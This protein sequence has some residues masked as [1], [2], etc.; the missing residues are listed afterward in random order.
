MRRGDLTDREKAI[1]EFIVE[2]KR[3]GITPTV[4]EIGREVGLSS[5]ATVFF[6]LRKL[7]EKGY[8]QRGRGARSIVVKDLIPSSFPLVGKVKAGKPNLA[9][10]GIEDYVNLPIDR[11]LHPNAFLLK[12][13]GD[14]MKDAGILDNDL[15]VIDPDVEV[16]ENDI[17]VSLIDGEEVTVKRFKI[18]KGKPFLFPENPEYKPIKIDKRIK[19]IGKV[20][21]VWR[22]Y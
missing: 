11:D 2:S 6:Y 13:S 7:E 21:G 15:V 17:C 3:K 1:L 4:R 16:K 20:I 8:I 22:R 10:Q 14:S 19:I 18:K 12:V 9:V 5:T